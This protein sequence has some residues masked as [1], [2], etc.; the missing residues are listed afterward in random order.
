[1][2]WVQC[3]ARLFARNPW[4]LGG[5]GLCA[6]VLISVFKLIPVVGSL[7]V[8]FVA[9]ILLASAYLAIDGV[10]KLKMALPARL[11]AV[12]IRQSPRELVRVFRDEKR[13]VPAIV[14]AFFT[15]M[16]TLIVNIVIE[17]VAG[18]AW[19]KPLTSLGGVPLVTVVVLALLALIVYAWVGA[20]LV[21]ALPLAFLRNEPLIPAIVR[22][23]RVSRNNIGALMV[24]LGLGLSPYLLG[25]LASYVSVWATL[26]IWILA[27]AV[28]LP[29][30]A[31]SLYCSYR[32]VLPVREQPPMRSDP[33]YAPATTA[34]RAGFSASSDHND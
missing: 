32:T 31:T 30:V 23:L 10:A 21:Y 4:L 13:L 9:P 1:M 19:S 6:A 27:G 29:L 5:M 2:R 34:A 26:L 12:A 8:A 11:R 16:V 3:G 18:A 14:T 15:V 22:S 25:A 24:I 7:L 17:Y 28:V 20:A 33:A